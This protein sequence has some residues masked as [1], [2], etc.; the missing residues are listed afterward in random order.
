MPEIRAFRTVCH[1]VARQ[2]GGSL[3]EFPAGDGVT[4]SFHQGVIAYRDRTVAVVGD[5]VLPL[6]AVAEPRVRHGTN[7]PA[8]PLTF[9]D[10]PDLTAALAA[11]PGLRVLTKADL[12]AG[13][14]PADWPHVTAADVRYWRPATVGEA[15]F[16]YWD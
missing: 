14:T 5:R 12:A 6:F 8:G 7:M 4:P 3:V 11:I 15:L 2:T 10:V 13:F 1:A 9:L 16:N